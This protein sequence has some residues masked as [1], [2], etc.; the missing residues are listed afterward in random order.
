MS[1]LFSTL[2]FLLK[3]TT[4]DIYSQ[5]RK[6]FLVFA[7]QLL[8]IHFYLISPLVYVVFL[9]YSPQITPFPLKLHPYTKSYPL[10]SPFPP[11]ISPLSLPCH[12]FFIKFHLQNIFICL[13]FNILILNFSLISPPPP[14]EIWPIILFLE[15]FLKL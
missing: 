12:L 8:Q 3:L 5:E 13:T 15:Q 2:T 6:V 7:Q 11:P 10:F 4:L 9:L 1:Q 14:P